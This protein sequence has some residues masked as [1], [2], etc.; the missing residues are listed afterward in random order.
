MPI[1]SDI[2]TSLFS[3][4]LSSGFDLGHVRDQAIASGLDGKELTAFIADLSADQ[5]AEITAERIELRRAKF[6][7]VC[8]VD[9]EDLFLKGFTDDVAS[10][11]TDLLRCESWGRKEYRW[12]GW[13]LHF[14][15]RAKALGLDTTKW[16]FDP[17]STKTKS[18]PYAQHPH[19]FGAG[20]IKTP[21]PSIA[22]V[23]D[24][25]QKRGVVVAYGNSW[26][27]IDSDQEFVEKGAFTKTIREWG[28]GGRGRIAH[29]SD[30]NPTSRIGKMQELVEDEVGLRFVSKLSKNSKGRDALIEYEEGILNEHSI[31]YDIIGWRRDE[32]RDAL[33]LTELKLYE[34]SPV[35]WGANMFTPTVDV[36]EFLSDPLAITWLY[37]QVQALERA[38]RREVTD[39]KAVQIEA[40]LERAERAMTAVRKSLLGDS[41]PSDSTSREE[42]NSDD[43]LVAQLIERI[44]I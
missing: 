38:S 41:P 34:I 12:A 10:R 25:D 35:T 42:P 13:H 9:P 5:D 31:G 20:Y 18:A 1:E 15:D 8:N 19:P 17:S 24:V 22:G 16:G 11:T 32:D 21:G 36:K 39:L 2:I 40:L 14:I 44:S 4:L 26:D 29:L 6:L 43:E 28:P 33:G 7:A 23:K 3:D 27:V 30:H 37:D